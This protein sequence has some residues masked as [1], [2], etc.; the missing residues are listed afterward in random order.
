MKN[1][2]FVVSTPTDVKTGQKST[3][4]RPTFKVVDQLELQTL[5]SQGVNRM[6]ICKK[7]GISISTLKRRIAEMKGEVNNETSEDTAETLI[8]L[9][10]TNNCSPKT[11]EQQPLTKNMSFSFHDYN[12][13]NI[14]YEKIKKQMK[15]TKTKTIS[16]EY[17]HV[18]AIPNNDNNSN[19]ILSPN[20]STPSPSLPLPSKPTKD[21]TTSNT[22]CNTTD[23]CKVG[24]DE[25]KYV[26]NPPF[27][28]NKKCTTS[29]VNKMSLKFICN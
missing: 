8:S 19:V 29:V 22:F 15:T 1:L 28:C 7:L 5:L 11:N 24:A 27:A 17:V 4:R 14:R 20:H 26:S 6:E 18:Q 10:S 25:T 21:L 3:N 9:S 13:N 2:V 16:K 23:F 12:N